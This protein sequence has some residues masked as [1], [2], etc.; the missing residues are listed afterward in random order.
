MTLEK[1][2]KIIEILKSDEEFRDK[3]Y[4][5]RIEV[6]NCNNAFNSESIFELLFAEIYDEHKADIVYSWLHE[7][8]RGILNSK[9]EIVS[10]ETVEELYNYI[11]NENV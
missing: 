9:G 6:G 2:K 10:L 5:L 8:M 1:F 3:L 11:N 7:D 4:E